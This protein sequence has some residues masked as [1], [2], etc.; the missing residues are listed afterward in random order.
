MWFY[1]CSILYCSAILG[2]CKDCGIVLYTSFEQLFKFWRQ[3]RKQNVTKLLML[4]VHGFDIEQHWLNCDY[5]EAMTTCMRRCVNWY[6]DVHYACVWVRGM[7]MCAYLAAIWMQVWGHAL[8][9][10]TRLRSSGGSGGDVFCFVTY[11]CDWLIL[12]TKC[13][14]IVHMFM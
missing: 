11:D 9:W 13:T 10:H 7:H 4:N 3:Q 6:Y 2:V 8:L 5:S 1:C 14:D 12:F